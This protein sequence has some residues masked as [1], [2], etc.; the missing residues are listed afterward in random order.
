MKKFISLMALAGMCTLNV[1]AQADGDYYIKHVETGK[2]LG[3]GNDWG[4]RASLSDNNHGMVFTLAKQENGTYTIDSHASNGGEKHYL[5]ANG[6][7]DAAVANFTFTAVEGGYQITL[8]EGQYLA[9]EATGTIVNVNS[10]TPAV[11]ELI[12]IGAIK[13]AMPEATVENP[14]DVT[15][16]I[17]NNSFDSKV[18]NITGEYN[19]V[20]EADNKN[21]S[22]GKKDTPNNPCAESYHSTFTLTQTITGV[23]KGVYAVKVQG[24]YR[25]DGEFANE[26]VFFANDE[27]SPFP[28]KTGTENSMNDASVSFTNGSYYCKPIVIEV[29]DGQIALGARNTETT[30]W[31]IW[32]NFELYYYGPDADVNAVKNAALYAQVQE[33]LAEAKE[34]SETLADAKMDA[35]VKNNLTEIVKSENQPEL[36]TE[37]DYNAYIAE[38]TAVIGSAK[39]SVTTYA[40]A[41][42]LAD[43]YYRYAKGANALVEIDDIMAAYEEGTLPENPAQVIRDR[44]YATLD[45]LK[46]GTKNVTATYIIDAGFDE[47]TNGVEEWQLGTANPYLHKADNPN[48]ALK[49]GTKFVE[50]WKQAPATLSDAEMVQTI[51]LPAGQYIL[52]AEAQNMQQGDASVNP[53]G[54]FLFGPEGNTEITNVAATVATTFTLTEEA[55]VTIGAKLDRCT[56]NW[57]CVDNFQL[58]QAVEPTALNF[59]ITPGEGVV[60]SLQT[61]T[62]TPGVDFTVADDANIAVFCGRMQVGGWNAEAIR[63]NTTDGVITLTLPMEV[64]TPGNYT[65]DIPEGTFL[66]GEGDYNATYQKKLW[67]IAETPMEAPEFTMDEIGAHLVFAEDVALTPEADENPVLSVQQN[68]EEVAKAVCSYNDAKYNIIDLRFSPELS[69]GEYTLVVPADFFGANDRPGVTLAAQNIEI[70]INVATAISEVAANGLK[71]GKFV[72]NNSIVIVKNGKAYNAAG[73]RIRK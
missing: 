58:F 36:T 38:L 37:E 57:V 26:P 41:L 62:I 32:D 51:T 10:A 69:I 54:F 7:T 61:I 68:G 48:F 42:R 17:H 19:W 13:E 22:G 66:W 72:K 53:G 9:P 11:W 63:S 59:V 40:N 1:S 3:Q 64:K 18:Y 56:G 12:S 23:P 34:L 70:T 52:T 45:A 25:I 24:F 8:G 31:C 27:T 73:A 21:L 5:G 33:L 15:F 6:Y 14:L 16:Y 29:T 28:L 2:Y 67:T 44:Y 60:E 71:D 55:E 43:V 46:V 35:T 50:A 39:S 47:T 4:T 65:I 20:M 49:T 30:L